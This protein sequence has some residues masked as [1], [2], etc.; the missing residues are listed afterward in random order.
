[1]T[2]LLLFVLGLSVLAAPAWAVWPDADEPM[3]TVVL[4]RH[5]AYADDDDSVD[6][7]HLVTLGRQQARMVAERLDAMPIA[8]DSLQASTLNRARETAEIVAEWFPDLD[9]ELHDDLREC[10]MRTRRQ[11][12]MERLDPDEAKACEDRLE[13]TFARLFRPVEGESGR[14]D[15]V[16]CHGNV[17]RWFVCKIL[18]VDPEAWLQMGIAHCSI[19]VVQVRTDGSMKLLSFAD[20]GHV[21]YPMTTY[22]G[23][24][25]PQ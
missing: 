25:A 22:G 18:D 8:F 2:R 10:T 19:T 23:N 16:I 7:G 24:E 9:L 6:E 15:I 4:V 21:P 20:S 17:I 1:V 11:D 3:R 13:G 5:G 12:I 14:H